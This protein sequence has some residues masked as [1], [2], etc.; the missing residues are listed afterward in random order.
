[1][2]RPTTVRFP[3]ELLE[4]LEREAARQHRPVS[5]VI[6]EAAEKYIK[7]LAND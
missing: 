3:P 1:M 7:E 6:R 2:I 4:A 5:W